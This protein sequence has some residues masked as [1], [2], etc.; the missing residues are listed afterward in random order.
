MP[1][2]SPKADPIP[3][4]RRFAAGPRVDDFH[5]WGIWDRR[6]KCWAERPCYMR[7]AAERLEKVMAEVLA[8]GCAD[9]EAGGVR[10][11]R[12]LPFAAAPNDKSDAWGVRDHEGERW[13]E[14]PVYS[15]SWAEELAMVLNETY[16]AGLAEAMIQK[17][18]ERGRSGEFG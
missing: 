16:A 17:A 9:G 15:Q 7:E 4:A 10:V 2:W 8:A 1:D 18:H 11:A 12:G 14:P 13:A 5:A 3:G 6:L